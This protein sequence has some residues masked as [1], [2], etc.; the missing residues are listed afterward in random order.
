MVKTRS[1]K[2]SDE[3]K[4]AVPLAR[5]DDVP[6]PGNSSE[7]SSATLAEPSAR[8]VTENREER[9][10]TQR[11]DRRVAFPPIKVRVKEI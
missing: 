2:A 8:S 1:Q 4:E 5:K 9:A 3:A 11:Q 7:A 10:Y 6:Q